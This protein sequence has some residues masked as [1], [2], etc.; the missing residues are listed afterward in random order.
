MFLFVQ[1]PLP[2]HIPVTLMIQCHQYP[3]KTK[4]DRMDTNPS[5]RQITPIDE[6]ALR[7]ELMQTAAT[8]VAVPPPAV[9][10]TPMMQPETPPSFDPALFPVKPADPTVTAPLEASGG[11]SLARPLIVSALLPIAVTL[12]NVGLLQLFYG[13]LPVSLVGDI[14][15]QNYRLIFIASVITGI[16][17]LVGIASRQYIKSSVPHPRLLA[18]ALVV[19]VYGCAQS[20]EHVLPGTSVFS[21]DLWPKD[22]WVYFVGP[23][24]AVAATFSFIK[25]VKHYSSIKATNVLIGSLIGLGVISVGIMALLDQYVTKQYATYTSVTNTSLSEDAAGPA[26]DSEKTQQ[27]TQNQQVPNGY[28]LSQS[29]ST[30]KA[31]GAEVEFSFPAKDWTG[32]DAGAKYSFIMQTSNYSVEDIAKTKPVSGAKISLVRSISWSSAKEMKEYIQNNAPFGYSL[33][34]EDVRAKSVYVYTY[35]LTNSSGVSQGGYILN[36]APGIGK[37]LAYN[38]VFNYATNDAAGYQKVFDD[39]VDSLRF[40]EK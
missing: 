8:P 32:K 23:L 22:A 11:D 19:L 9:Q 27:S 31:S 34:N 17:T 40:I 12:L 37:G 36:D 6:E 25:L 18:G 33:T 30:I 3:T 38:F 2:L 35:K 4:K 10:M 28:T 13:I 5:P 26:L 29:G 7:R 24:I 20:L 21:S 1:M 14:G 15:P 39:F 16:I